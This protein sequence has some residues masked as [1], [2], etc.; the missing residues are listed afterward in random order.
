MTEQQ[1]YEVV[2][3][4]PDFELRRY[5]A[6]VVAEVD[7]SGP[8]ESAGNRAFQALF[9]YITGQNR[10]AS[11]IA[12]TAPVVQEAAR[13]QKVAMT[14][15]VVQTETD[16]GEHVVAFVLP[17]SMTAETAPVPTDPQVRIRAVPE[18]LAAATRYSGRWAETAYRQHL[19]DLE[20]ATTQA[21]FVPVGVARFARFDPP[22]KPWFLRRNEVVQDVRRANGA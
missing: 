11:S 4:Y 18:C 21:G 10:S 20:A 5:P 19:A 8:F 15:P 14:A 3:K 17:A 2:E 7:V 6:H 1:P 13:P 22:Y 9:G 12:M 16:T